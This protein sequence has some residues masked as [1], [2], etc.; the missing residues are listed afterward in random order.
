M[1]PTREA[2]RSF[3]EQGYL[4][5]NDLI[6]PDWLRQIH[7]S[8]VE[9]GCLQVVPGS[10][11]KGLMKHDREGKVFGLFLPGYFQPREDAVPV[12]LAAGSAIFFGLLL[13]HGS[14]ANHSDQE[15]RA[16]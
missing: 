7:A 14:D 8:T 15:R 4:V 16:V 5:V 12:P 2:I 6:P 9:N 10:P 3:E 13:I 1:V 11:R